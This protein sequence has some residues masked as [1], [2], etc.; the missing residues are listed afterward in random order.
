M[1]LLIICKYLSHLSR[2]FTSFT[3]HYIPNDHPNQW[4]FEI[5][6]ANYFNKSCCRTF[7]ERRVTKKAK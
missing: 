5:H 1:S 6:K 3:Y 7:P 2:K 4:G